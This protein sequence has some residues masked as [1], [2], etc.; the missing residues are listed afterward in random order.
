MGVATSRVATS[1]RNEND[2]AL[3]TVPVKMMKRSQSWTQRYRTFDGF[4]KMEKTCETV[5]YQGCLCWIGIWIWRKT[6]YIDI[7]IWILRLERRPGDDRSYKFS[8]NRPTVGLNLYKYIK[9]FF[10]FFLSCLHHTNKFYVPSTVF[11]FYFLK[12][13]YGPILVGTSYVDKPIRTRS[14]NLPFVNYFWFF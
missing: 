9:I 7:I 5:R 6:K 12:I 10:Y 8:G 11:L 14:S 1:H 4:R 13:F 2:V 3:V